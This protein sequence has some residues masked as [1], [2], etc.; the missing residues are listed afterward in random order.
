MIE[1]FANDLS[2]VLVKGDALV[3]EWRADPTRLVAEAQH[4]QGFSLAM[5]NTVSVT[6]LDTHTQQRP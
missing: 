6:E 2:D 4:L 5:L 3:R 1:S